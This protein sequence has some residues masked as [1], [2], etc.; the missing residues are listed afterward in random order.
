MWEAVQLWTAF[1]VWRSDNDF[2]SGKVQDTRDKLN[3]ENM[4][5]GND[6][7]PAPGI[8]ATADVQTTSTTDLTEQVRTL[9]YTL[10]EQRGRQ[11]GYAEQD[12]LQAEI[13]IVGLER[14]FK[15]AA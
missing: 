3:G 11:D 12:W 13:E 14:T 1:A 6:V 9:A 5:T 8:S 15:A 7:K 10:Y 4:K 2:F